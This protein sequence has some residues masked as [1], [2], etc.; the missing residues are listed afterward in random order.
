MHMYIYIHMY[1]YIH[2]YNYIHMYICTTMFGMCVYKDKYQYI[3][4]MWYQKIRH[5]RVG[6]GY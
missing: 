3:Y 6:Y 1:T 2:V 4:S 5:I